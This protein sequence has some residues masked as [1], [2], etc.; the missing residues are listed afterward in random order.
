MDF[1]SVWAQMEECQ[2]LGLAKAIGV[3]NFSCRKLEN[4]LSYATIPPA[5]NQVSDHLHSFCQLLM[6][7]DQYSNLV[8]QVTL[9]LRL[10]FIL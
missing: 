3:C 5:V 7:I 10:M 8:L 9:F 6:N 1:K 2:R 4:L